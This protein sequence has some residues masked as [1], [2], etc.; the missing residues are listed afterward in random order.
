M[1]SSETIPLLKAKIIA[2]AANNQLATAE[3]GKRLVERGILYAPD[4]VINAGGVINVAAEMSEGGYSVESVM[5]RV[6][7]IADTLT[8]IF[9]R[10]EREGRTTDAVAEAMAREIVEQA[11]K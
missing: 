7:K 4:Y 10:A 5:P 8:K 9:Q 2:G 11:R 1:L 6:E 3:D